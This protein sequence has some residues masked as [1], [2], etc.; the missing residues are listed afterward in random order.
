MDA[1]HRAPPILFILR[2]AAVALSILG[3]V[4]FYF[5]LRL[6]HDTQLPQ[7]WF[8]LATTGLVLAAASIP[9][10]LITRGRKTP[11]TFLS[12]VWIGTLGLLFLSLLLGDVF[13]V[14]FSLAPRAVDGTIAA[15]V[16]A[17]V[18]ASLVHARRLVVRDVSIT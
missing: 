1:V 13:R 8:A 11:I 16:G 9:F 14:G 17:A 6:V 5:W 10:S 2:F 18:I 3:A 15:T 12:Y 4:H 7:P